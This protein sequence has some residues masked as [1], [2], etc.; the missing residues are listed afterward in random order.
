MANADILVVLPTLGDRID[1]LTETLKAIE[2]QRHDVNLSL[3]VVAPV[4]AKVARSLALKYGA[5]LVDDPGT[6]SG[7]PW[8]DAEDFHVGRLGAPPDGEAAD[9]GFRR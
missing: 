6:A 8:I 3:V 1:T 7:R 2:T 5:T 4:R 9:T